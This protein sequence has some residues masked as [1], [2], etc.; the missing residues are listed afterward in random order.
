MNML[1]L[2]PGIAV[3]LLVLVLER[4][5]ER[6]REALRGALA[7]F[8]VVAVPLG[9]LHAPQLDGLGPRPLLRRRRRPGPT[10]IVLPGAAETTSANAR[11]RVQLHVAVLP[12]A[13]SLDAP[14]LPAY[15]LRQIWFN[16]FIGQFGWLDYGFAQWVYNLALL[17]AVGIVAL[18]AREL[19]TGRAVIRS[20]IGELVTYLTLVAGLLVLIGGVSYIAR[21]GGARATSSRATSSPCSRC[22]AP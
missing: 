13:A 6:R 12:A 17:I 22:T 8:A 5:R 2:A 10:G 19:I 16:G 9:D 3:G 18:A 7:A 20:R 11:R 21:I 15:P 14:A 4:G 1:G